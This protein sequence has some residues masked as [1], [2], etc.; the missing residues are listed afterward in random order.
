MWHTWRSDKVF[1]FD[2]GVHRWFSGRMLACHAGGPG[3][4]PGRCKFWLKYDLWGVEDVLKYHNM[5][6][7][8]LLTLLIIGLVVPIFDCSAQGFRGVVVITFA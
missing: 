2:Y 5:V 7:Y 4:I 3:S 1:N 8:R 6:Y